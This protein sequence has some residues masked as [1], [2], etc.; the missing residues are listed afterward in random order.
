MAKKA[1]K[2]TLKVSVTGSGSYTVTGQR[3][4]KRANRSKSFK[5]AVGT[6]RIKAAGATVTPGKVTVRKGK[7]VKVA[8][9]FATPAPT[10]PALIPVD[11]PAATAP[12]TR[13]ISTSATG[14]QGDQGSEWPVWSPDGTRIAFPSNATNLV[15]GDTN[16]QLDIFV[17]TL[18]TGAIQ[19]VSTDGNGRQANGASYSVAWSPDS[20]RIAF[21]SRASNLVTGDSNNLPDIFIKTLATGATQIVSSSPFELW[22]PEP[23]NHATRSVR[24]TPSLGGFLGSNH[25]AWSPDGQ[26]IAFDSDT[27]NLVVGDSNNRSDIF[28]KTLATSGIPGMQ[29]VSTSTDGSQGNGASFSPAWSPD[30]KKLAFESRATDLVPSDTNARDDIF[31]KTLANGQITRI[32]TNA[33]GNQAVAPADGGSFGARWSPDGARIMFTSDSTNLVPADT[34]DTEEI[35]IKTLASGDVQRVATNA[36][37]GQAAGPLR[38][39]NPQW[40]PDGRQVVFESGAPNLVPGDTNGI[41]DIFVKTLATGAIKRVSTDSAGA[42]SVGGHQGSSAPYWAP[43][44]SSV[45]FFSSATNLVPGDT[46]ATYDVFVKRL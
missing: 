34:N 45:A 8:V 30:G 32:S 44:G 27:S 10:P 19:R 38:S 20:M 9:V 23:G 28:V 40:S 7:S 41:S 13:R 33:A 14:G 22:A 11:P 18:A 46:N 31:V 43:D 29:R 3:V 35:F 39:D 12:S 2:G 26:R 21:A 16:G 25:P 15:P 37:G 36:S 42:Q 17:K 6:Y 4:R 24:A 5:L 1:A